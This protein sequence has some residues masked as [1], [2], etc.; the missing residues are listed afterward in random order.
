MKLFTLLCLLLLLST[1]FV[2]GHA[3]ES[4]DDEAEALAHMDGMEGM[5]AMHHE[6]M[7]FFHQLSMILP[8]SHFT[9]GRWFAGIVLTLFVASFLYIVYLLVERLVKEK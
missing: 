9:A 7:G 8:F 1:T 3:G 4:H 5:D 2:L 6:G